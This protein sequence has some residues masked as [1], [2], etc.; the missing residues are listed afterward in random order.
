LFAAQAGISLYQA[1]NAFY[2]NNSNKWGVAGKA[3]I[4]AIYF[5]GD[6]L[7]KRGIYMKLTTSSM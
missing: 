7:R 2:T 5:I 6:E 3:G 4:G 1:G